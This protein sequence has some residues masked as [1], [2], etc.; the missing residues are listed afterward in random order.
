FVAIVVTWR[1]TRTSRQVLSD[2]F[3]RRSLEQVMWANGNIYFITLLC[4]NVLDLILASLTIAFESG[5]GNYV[6]I[7][8]NPI[9]A[10]L[11]CRFLL[12]LYET[13]TLLEAGGSSLAPS[14]LSLHF[15]GFGL[16]ETDAPEDS[17]L[18]SAFAGPIHSFPEDAGR[19]VDRDPVDGE[20]EAGPSAPVQAVATGDS[21]TAA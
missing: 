17:N 5:I 11:S 20:P 3:Q 13:N 1:A 10:V 15:T 6:L 12:D 8:L 16:E 18:L 2:S 9:I 19:D 14:D 7:F 4:I 21:D